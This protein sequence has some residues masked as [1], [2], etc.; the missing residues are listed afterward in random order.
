MSTK[1]AKSRA[2]AAVNGVVTP[3]S[4]AKVPV[5]DRGFLFG[6]AVYEVVRVFQGAPFH[7]EHHIVRLKNSAEG[8]RFST[9]PSVETLCQQMAALLQASEVQFGSLYIQVT[10]GQT[11]SRGIFPGKDTPCTVVI[12]VEDKDPY[13]ET[14]Y[15]EGVDVVTRPEQRWLRA[16]LKTVNLVP[17]I[18]A[19]RDALAC[20]AWEVIWLGEGKRLLEGGSTNLFI[21]HG[22]ELITP[23]LG[24]RVLAGVT[25]KEVLELAEDLGIPSSVRPVALKEALTAREVMLTGTSTEV[26]GV[27][28]I[29]G[30]SIG[31]GKPGPI[32]SR[33]R[34]ALL[35]RMQ[36]AVLQYRDSQKYTGGSL[37]ESGFPMPQ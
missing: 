1:R 17:R 23:P 34:R 8:L 12:T 29:D 9:F 19:K 24:E 26:L 36:Q 22:D 16:D 4:E 33:L 13:P 6:D 37:Q 20:G 7:L 2:L 30:K 21:V 14:L 35:D 27:R 25:R 3:L 18:L 32:A 11:A 28:S 5:L 31:D 10:R 15:A